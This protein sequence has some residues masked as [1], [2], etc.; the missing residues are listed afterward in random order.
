MSELFRNTEAAAFDYV[1]IALEREIPKLSGREK[2]VFDSIAKFGEPPGAKE[3]SLPERVVMWL[4]E[5]Y[6][7]ASLT[8][9]A[10]DPTTKIESERLE[11]ANNLRFIAGKLERGEELPNKDDLIAIPLEIR[12]R[13][14]ERALLGEE[15]T[16]PTFFA[17]ELDETRFRNFAEFL[18]EGEVYFHGVRETLSKVAPVEGSLEKQR[19]LA[20]ASNLAS[21]ILLQQVK[22]ERGE[23]IG[24]NKVEFIRD[25]YSDRIMLIGNSKKAFLELHDPNFPEQAFLQMWEKDTDNLVVNVGYYKKT[26]V[27]SAHNQRGN[28][29]SIEDFAIW[30]KPENTRYLQQEISSRSPSLA[31]EFNLGVTKGRAVRR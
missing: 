8:N 13:Q 26:K 4:Y 10:Y 14:L 16:G 11:L 3:F 29:L 22:S 5:N 31:Q 15:S 12:Q 6:E 1:R 23:N 19:S 28:Q 18:E 21:Y 17:G 9:S 20:V 7:E 25:H 30:S 2:L 27:W 24:D